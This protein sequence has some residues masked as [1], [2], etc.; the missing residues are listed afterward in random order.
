MQLKDKLDLLRKNK[1]TSILDIVYDVDDTL[2]NLNDYVFGELGYEL[3]DIY[4]INLCNK[5]TK[6]QKKAILKYYRDP[7]VFASLS[8][9]EGAKDIC[10][11]ED[12]KKA[13]VWINS[14]NLSVEALK[15]KEKTLLSEIP[16]LNPSRVVLQMV[17]K[18]AK[19]IISG[20][21]IIEDSFEDLI[22]YPFYSIKILID[23]SYNQ[24]SIYNATD[25]QYGIIR[26]E[27]L[28]EANRII[29]EI[30]TL[31]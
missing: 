3:P 14:G 10:K 6:E 13:L 18:Q 19:V 9:V 30:I 25:D 27:S 17:D 7:N 15:I 16:N 21:I 26:V 22:R 2:N 23:K 29:K 5:Y 24:S 4:N 8:Y 31:W 1:V 12:T 20:D 11:I 28:T